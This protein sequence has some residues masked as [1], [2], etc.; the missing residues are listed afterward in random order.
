GINRAVIQPGLATGLGF[1]VPINLARDVAEQLLTT[2]VIRRAFLGIYSADL[3]P[4]VSRFYR[5]PVAQGIIVDEVQPNSPAA[6]SGLRRGDII[7]RMDDTP[8]LGRGD[9]TRF[10]RQHRTGDEISITAI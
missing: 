9:L 6:Q 5:L 3:T 10:L 1:A 8:I 2:G 7:V 4:E